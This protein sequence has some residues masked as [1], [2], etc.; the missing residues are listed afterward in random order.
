MKKNCHICL[1]GAFVLGML[2]GWIANEVFC[3]APEENRNNRGVRT[4]IMMK[5]QMQEAKS[6]KMLEDRMK[7][8]TRR[9]DARRQQARPEG[10]PGK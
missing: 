9:E 8:R 6:G 5:K 4:Q 10:R 1:A 7:Q 2:F 3:G